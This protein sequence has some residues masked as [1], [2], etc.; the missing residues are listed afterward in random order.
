MNIGVSSSPTEPLAAAASSTNVS[1]SEKLSVAAS[2]GDRR[3]DFDGLNDFDAGRVNVGGT[4][5]VAAKV[6]DGEKALVSGA[7][8][9]AA[10]DVA[11]N[12]ELV[13]IAVTRNGEL[14][15]KFEAANGAVIAAVTVPWSTGDRKPF[16]GR[17][18]RL[19]GIVVGPIVALSASGADKVNLPVTANTSECNKFFD[20]RRGVAA[21]GAVPLMRA[22]P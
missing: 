8:G 15:C 2:S 7:V 5:P 10:R 22:D 19:A 14:S 17:I 3:N 20:S 21:T 4:G 11:P 18:A 13:A 9:V 1:V 12:A 16:E 6:T